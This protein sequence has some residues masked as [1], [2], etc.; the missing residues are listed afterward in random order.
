MTM[1]ACRWHAGLHV[2]HQVVAADMLRVLIVSHR[3]CPAGHVVV[4][5]V[6]STSNSVVPREGSWDY[7]DS[8]CHRGGLGTSCNGHALAAGTCV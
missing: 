3:C 8:S 1:N 7:V 2:H 6:M 5:A 4:V